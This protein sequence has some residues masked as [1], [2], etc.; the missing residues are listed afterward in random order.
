M[1]LCTIEKNVETEAGM[2][3]WNLRII[4]GKILAR[5]GLVRFCSNDLRKKAYKTNSKSKKC[6]KLQ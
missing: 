2:H 6:N 5:Y 3:Y 4:F 1:E